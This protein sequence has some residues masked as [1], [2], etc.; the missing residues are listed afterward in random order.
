MR[1]IRRKWAE[2]VLPVLS[3]RAIA[4]AISNLWYR[5]PTAALM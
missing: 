4:L 2:C 5:D 1:N 3:L